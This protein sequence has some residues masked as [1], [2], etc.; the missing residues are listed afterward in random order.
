MIPRYS[1]IGEYS[2]ICAKMDCN[3]AIDADDLGDILDDSCVTEC[4]R[5]YDGWI[6]CSFPE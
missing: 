1:L 6:A 2:V 5:D 3:N 4:A